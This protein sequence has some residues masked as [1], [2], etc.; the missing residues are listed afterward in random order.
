MNTLANSPLSEIP[1]GWKLPNEIVRRLGSK[2]GKQRVIA[3]NKH[4]LIILHKPPKKHDNHRESIFFWKNDDGK[5]S[6]SERGNGLT[7]LK[8]FLDNYSQFGDAL[9]EEYENAE[10]SKDF[11]NLLEKIAPV[12]RSVKNMGNTLQAARDLIGEEMIDYRDKAEELSR[13]FELLYVDSK[14]GLDYAVAKKAE[15]QS[16]LQRK[17]VLAGHRLNMI[18]A[19]FLPITAAASLLGMNIPHGLEESPPWVYFSIVIVC[20]VLGLFVRHKVSRNE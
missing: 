3:E 6:A 19:L 11:F 1:P 17:A 5:W 8:D 7:A 4:V 12:Q 16:E 18:I 9:E 13:N 10:S 15:E 2:A 14:N 20:A